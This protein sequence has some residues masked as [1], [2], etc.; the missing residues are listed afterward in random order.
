MNQN[1]SDSQEIAILQA[2]TEQIQLEIERRICRA[3]LYG[4]VRTFWD[5]IIPDPFRYN[6]HIEYLC[7]EMQ[8]VGQWVID[9]EPSKYDLIINVPPGTTKSTIC[10]VFF[11]VW[12]WINA[13]WIRMISASHTN[14]LAI[15]H[16]ILA[17]D[18]MKSQ[19][20]RTL[21]P[22][23]VN[24]KSDQDNKTYYRNMRGGSRVATSV[25][26]NI[27]GKHG[28]IITIDDLIDPKKT[29][30]DVEREKANDYISRTLST[31]KVD[32]E[33]TPTVLIMQRLHELD[34]T[35]FL[36]FKAEESGKRIKHI[37]L[38][39]DDALGNIKPHLLKFMYKDG[40]LDANR[41][42]RNALKIMETDLGESDF[43]GQVRQSPQAPGGNILKR[44][45]FKPYED[46]PKERPISKIQS[47]DTAFKKTETS[48]YNCG[49]TFY[50]YRN[51]Y[52][53]EDAIF[54]KMEYP[55]LKAEILSY[56]AKHSPNIVLV[57]DKATG[58]PI[59][60]EL[61]RDNK[62]NFISIL[63]EGDKVQRAHASSSTVKAGNVYI[64]SNATWS[65]KLT[66]QLILFPNCQIK[67]IMDAFSQYINYIRD[68][69]SVPITR[70]VGGG[71]SKV[72]RNY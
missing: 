28:H 61:S 49:L 46:L 59:I 2:E 65:H 18:V 22:H 41:L 70:M 50:E 40:L 14:D 9:R 25:G 15:E 5:V 34:P 67:D 53:L 57:E 20:F 52:Y 36:L 45:W 33:N 44:E 56:E 11:H 19:K 62:I 30:S 42:N 38:P 43:T 10:S 51:G 21:F 31:R 26:G 68:N 48:A 23:R 32:K 24:F 6:W 39:G 37:C 72:T 29:A 58:T 71:K 7:N 60:Q 69:P 1:S 4:T 27:M 3:S 64:R 55:E 13:P 8:K 12:L 54:E 17:R 35:G 66:N 16:S 63:P 47:W